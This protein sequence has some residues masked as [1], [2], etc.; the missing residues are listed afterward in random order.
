MGSGGRPTTIAA[1]VL[2]LAMPLP[3]HSQKSPAPPPSSQKTP[4]P[5]QKKTAMPKVSAFAALRA[6]YVKEFLERFP[7]VATYLGAEGLDSAYAA[8]DG[9]LRD[10]SP[11]ALRAE[12]DTWAGFQA[13]LAK[14]DVKTLAEPDRI[15]A[16][17]MGAQLA[18]LVHNLDRH[19]HE[20][21]LDVFLEEPLRG[22][23]WALQ[24]MAPG[25]G[26]T[27]GTKAEWQGVAARTAAVP[28]YLKT[29]LANV[30]RG[31]SG[32]AIPDRRLI[33]A[34]VD[35][36]EST[37][38]YFE[39]RVAEKLASWG[40]D[41]DAGTKASVAAAGPSAAAAFREFRK[42]L[43]D[44]FFEPDGKALNPA[45]DRDRFA[46]GEAEYSWA[47]KNN[48]GV[49]RTP[50]ELH[51]YGKSEVAAT[52]GEM[53]VL[54]RRIA[55]DR[56]LPDASLASVLSSLAN[57]VPKNDAEMLSWYREACRRLVDFGRK[58]G[59]FDLPA[60]YRL[61]VVFT[62]PPLRD[63]IDAAYYPAPPFK[64]GGVGQFYVTPTGDDAAA[65]REHARSAIASLAAHEGFPGHDWYYQFMR[66]HAA[67]IPAI[68]WLTPGGV[69]DSLS[70]WEDSMS[71]EGW[72]LYCERLVGERRAD[73]PDGFYTPE[74]QLFQL[75]NQL[76]RDARVVI[77]T[78]IH[79]GFM[80][81]D[82]AVTYYARNVAF[83]K[84]AV[85]TDAAVNPDA[86]ERAGVAAARK[87][88]FRYSKWPTQAITYDLGK[89]EILALREESQAVEGPGF[90]ERRFHEEFLS[91]GQIPPGLFGARLLAK[92][93][94]RSAA[95]DAPD[96]TNVGISR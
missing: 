8:L 15:D 42:G 77:D 29:A 9:K 89:A 53:T 23:E 86:A 35:A 26:G 67:S 92:A 18:F 64:T 51:A 10:Y 39:K 34:A 91:E 33:M 54:A 5:K 73:F 85:S 43:L 25:A 31:A 30:R 45:F 50:R 90:S 20:K 60:D 70:M 65:L 66:S 96:S 55:S 36:A 84:G 2:A 82:D 83:V 57:D 63:T 87:E 37:A 52:L 4:V 3:A 78:G 59:M 1:I 71:S 80:S 6:E 44:L 88:V 21:A 17:V 40:V 32:N 81:F 56:D 72:A 76:L 75:Q 68:R 38:V 46:A 48:L 14:I 28:L 22:V 79:C 19:V 58:T 69:E 74:E 47:L 24:G 7:V 41:L 13:R 95:T 12:R 94:A 27:R 11:V 62:P 61:D 49:T 16:S 93:R